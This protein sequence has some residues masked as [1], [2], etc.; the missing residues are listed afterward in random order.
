[1][2][3]GIKEIR[4]EIEE[5]KRDRKMLEEKCEKEK[6]ELMERIKKMERKLM[7]RG[8]RVGRGKGRR[9]GGKS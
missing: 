3:G 5:M 8:E 4:R 1:M 7:E 2:K 9:T 6:E